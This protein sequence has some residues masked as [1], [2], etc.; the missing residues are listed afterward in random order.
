[1]CV[2]VLRE[3]RRAVE[4][5]AASVVGGGGDVGCG[6]RARRRVRHTDIATTINYFLVT[7]SLSLSLAHDNV[8][9]HITSHITPT[10]G[11]GFCLRIS[12]VRHAACTCWCY[13]HFFE[14]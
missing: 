10:C 2:V 7:H 1:M 4:V 11:V 8:T 12:S 6:V 9:L 13:Y 5:C 14:S 3:R